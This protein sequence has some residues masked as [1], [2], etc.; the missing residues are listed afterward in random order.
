MNN[1]YTKKH[2]FFLLTFLFS[3]TLFAQNIAV[4]E[5]MSSNVTS[6]LD[7][8]GSA[9]D[10]IE[11]TNYGTEI[12]SLNGFGLTDDPTIPY[13]WTFPNVILNPNSYLLVWAS[14]KNRIVVGQPLHTNFKISSNEQIILTNP[15]GILLSSAPATVLPQNVSLGRQPDGTGPYVYFY[16]STPN[17][18]NSG[19]GLTELL[20]PPTFS[21]NSGV[22]T[23]PFD[24]TIS[25][26]NPNAVIIYTLDGSEPNINNL[27]GTNFQYKNI[28]P[29]EVNG[30][31]GP[32]LSE[33]YKSFQYLNPINIFDK[34]ALPDKLTKKNSHQ[35]AIYIPPIP[36]RK[37]MVLKA[38]SFVNGI[39]STTVSKSYFVWSGGNPYNFP[40]V[41]LQTQENNLFDY[42][43]GTYTSGIDF[44]TWRANNPDNTQS[45]RPDWNNYARSGSLW[46]YPM[47]VE[48]L[49]N[50]VS[51]LNQNA[52]YRIHG[53]NSR[54][55]VIKN[56][57]FYADS[58]YE[59]RGDFSCNLFNVPIFE[60]PNLSNNKFKRI[61][62]R[63]DGSGGSVAYD[64][65]FN[66]LMQPIY[67]GVNR[68]QP[69]IHF[70]NGEYWGIS[71]MRDWMD[72]YHYANNF[73]LNK[74]N[75]AIVA[76]GGSNCNLDVGVSADYDDYINLQNYITDND[77][78]NENF[79]VQATN[80]LDIVSFIDHMVVEI[81][82]GTNG[83]ERS[84]WKTRTPE[85]G[86]YGDGKWRT[87]IK[88]FDSALKTNEDWLA[89]WA[90]IV[91]SPNEIMFTRLLANT[92]FKTHFIN[93]F[94]DLINSVF[95]TNN[96]SSVVNSTF[97][98]V[99][100]YLTENSNRN[101]ATDFYA[102]IDKLNLIS[103]GTEHPMVQRNSIRSFFNIAN[104][105]NIVLNVS[106]TSA[107]IIKINTI[108]VSNVTPGIAEN[109]YPWTG[110]YFKNIPITLTAKAKQGYI[111]SHWSGDISG[112]NPE[113]TFT[114][115]GDKQVQ[116][117]FILDPNGLN[118]VYFW[119]MNSTI[120]NNLPLQN[121]NATYSNNNLTASLQF[122]SCLAGYPF[123]LTDP[124]WRVAAMER[125]NAPTPLNY[126]S[127]ANGDLPYDSGAMKGIQIKQPFKNGSLENVLRIVF[128]TTGLQQIKISFAVETDGA[129]NALVFDYWDGTNWVNTGISNPTTA[130]GVGYS[131]VEVNLSQVLVANNQTGFQF[132]IRFDGSNMF[133]S[134]GKR[135]Q[136][137]NIAIEAQQILSVRNNDVDLKF[138]AY[139][140]PAS[141][142]VNVKS[143]E[144]ITQLELYN[145]YGQ[146]VRT[147]SPKT[148]TFKVDIQDLPQGI[149]LLK[150]KSE[151]EKEKVIKIIK[152]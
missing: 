83:Y 18:S 152:N 126:F 15:M 103:Y 122:N 92:G 149:Y 56:L 39:G 5:I 73:D 142:F 121:L 10:W 95:S 113:I 139:P 131:L 109:P 46:E 51:V 138:T 86:G 63:G 144:T 115:D 143:S 62:L 118:V 11:L 80:R 55:Y 38:K 123:T 137:N 60:A 111:F 116:A 127:S 78:A 67:N 21:Q 140:N 135:V 45:Y 133:L 120:P 101:P 57:R 91:G 27:S 110:I 54:T 76:C 48:V 97:D 77:M 99:S 147:L 8:D 89:H 79:Y 94:A 13:K 82:S 34:S 88:D 40:I 59:E 117:N 14:S 87:S 30:S 85:N 58:N 145:L 146:I 6:I 36:V 119:F 16:Q 84:F 114:P 93:R 107:G 28:Y 136:F 112:T 104:N 22:F 129:A 50:S 98:E 31:P 61:L 151:R 49:N 150:A 132:R 134:E 1:Y 7:E 44:D 12:V 102:P 108:D 26:P 35:D 124:N 23:A 37:G 9:Q 148:S 24:L 3:I 96:F 141:T 29:I 125:K 42:N 66:R 128:S 71:A 81:Y 53:A 25:H 90:S 17:A 130:I 106:D 2:F 47:N 69:V 52:G 68:V 100:P 20:I 4:N 65:V 19:I 64:V 32:F 72:E 43:I 41:S 74:D 70:I 75:I 33:S 105:V